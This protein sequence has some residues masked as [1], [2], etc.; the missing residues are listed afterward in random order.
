MTKM[1]YLL[2]FNMDWADEHDVPALAVM[3]EKR[4]KKWSETKLSISANLG[5]GGD[6][7]CE[8]FQG[9]TGKELIEEGIVS[10]YVVDE[11]FAKVFKKANL[12][13]LS[14]SNV[15][16]GEEYEGDEDDD[17]DEDDEDEVY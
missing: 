10:K 4:F 16:D 11:S 3:D 13:S 9:Y 8:E 17:E 2:T 7:F 1:K 14:L 6:C 12:E 5:N 15:F